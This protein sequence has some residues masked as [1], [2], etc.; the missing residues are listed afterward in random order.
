MRIN[1]SLFMR[2]YYPFVNIARFFAIFLV[3]VGH[4]TKNEF[5]FNSIFCFHM[6]LFFILSGFLFVP[7][8]NLKQVAVKKFKSLIVPYLFFYALTLAY[9]WI[10]ESRFRES[11]VD[12]EWMRLLPFVL[13]CNYGASMSHN[14]VLWF[15]PALFCVELLADVLYT[16]VKNEGIRVGIV[17]AIGAAGFVMSEVG[18][19]ELPWGISQAMV[20]LPFFVL[21]IYFQSLLQAL[22]LSKLKSWMLFV[23]SA[24]VFVCLLGVVGKN[25]VQSGLFP[26]I[27]LFL[28]SSVIGSLMVISLA[29]ICGRVPVFEALGAGSVTLVV[30]C[31][32]EPLYRPLVIMASRLTG[33]DARSDVMLTLVVLAVTFVLCYLAS[34]VYNKYIASRLAR[35]ADRLLG[36]SVQIG[37][38]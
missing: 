32:H 36:E 30:M 24:A 25:S 2:T 15:L 22:Q 16:R 4:V 3:I 20:M 38:K 12:S 10:V 6:P 23:V 28:L 31:I 17:L 19:W 1:L 27:P 21:G 5:L 9:F 26:S 33:I 8:G 14:I 35:S 37:I 34:I 13:G 29:M 18:I 11:L 7:D